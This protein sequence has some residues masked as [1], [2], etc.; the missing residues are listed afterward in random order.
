MLLSVFRANKKSREFFNSKNSRPCPDMVYILLFAL[1]RVVFQFAHADTGVSYDF[2]V[3]APVCR[4]DLVI[5]LV[6]EELTDAPARR[7]SGVVFP[8]I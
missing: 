4:Y 2:Y 3:A 1:R 6:G 8:H 7:V 5:S